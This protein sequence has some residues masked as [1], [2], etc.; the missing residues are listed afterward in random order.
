LTNT[1]PNQYH[2]AIPLRLPAEVTG[3][4]QGLTLGNNSHY[5]QLGFKANS[6]YTGTLTYGIDNI[7]FTGIPEFT[8]HT[9]FSWENSF[10]G[11]TQGPDPGHVHTITSTGAT[12]GSTALQIDRTSVRGDGTTPADDNFVWGSIFTTTDQA[13]IDDFVPRINAAARVAFDV[14]FQDQFPANPSYTNFWVAF[15]DGTGA[16]YQAETPFFNING[17]LP[18]TKATLEIPIENFVDASAG[19]TK[20]LAVDGLSEEALQLAIRIAT[21][22]DYGAVY[23]ID[24][25][26]LITEV[27]NL[28]ADFND[29][30]VVDGADL[31]AWRSAF[32]PTAGADAD[33]DGDSDGNDFLVW[34]REASSPG[35]AVAVAAVPEPAAWL[36]A[37]AASL[38]L[39]GRRR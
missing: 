19:S 26:R 1:G 31:V 12:A 30:S 34:Q 6:G 38:A 33:G 10:E 37:V 21:S 4:G 24:N 25:F 36:L 3:A 7:R 23:Q 28:P 27:S 13:V 15:A 14:T 32:G 5:F 11:W 8:E 16:F 9:L 18:G 29:D 22:T 39:V 20:T 35:A 17:A 2:L